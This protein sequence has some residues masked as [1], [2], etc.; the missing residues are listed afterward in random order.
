M[1]RRRSAEQPPQLPGHDERAEK[2]RARQEFARTKQIVL[3]LRMVFWVGSLAALVN[4]LIWHALPIDRD[5]LGGWYLLITGVYWAQ[6]LLMAGDALFVM[7]AP[8]PWSIVA[9]SLHTL[10]T[11]LV[12]FTA[13]PIAIAIYAFLLLCYWAAVGQAARVQRLMAANPE[14]QIVRRRIAS[15]R[16]VSGGVADAARS[17]RHRERSASA[18]GRMQMIG[19][20]GGAILLLAGVIWWLAR[21]PAVDDRVALF[22]GAWARGD[23]NTIDHMFELGPGDGDARRLREGLQRRGWSE[24]RPALSPGAIDER[25]VTASAR[26]AVDGGELE[27]SFRR[28]PITELWVLQ[29]VGLPPIRTGPVA[30]GVTAL[31]TAWGTGT[32]AVIG[33]LTDGMSARFGNGLKA[34]FERRGWGER[35]PELGEGRVQ[36]RGD[37]EVRIT[38]DVDGDE[39][40]FDLEWWQPRWRIASVRLP[41]DA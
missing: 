30:D 19:I 31:R 14:L 26:F 32:D 6:V 22:A 18:K 36:E 9:A 1:P 37:G 33:M 20:V 29:R 4:A 3:Y 12:V 24:G 35:R 23:Q 13:G 41:R 38:F 28:D 8:F 25:E 10:S 40:R 27:L 5:E 34:A 16:V 21:P 2:A 39:L 11:I 17:R 7:R 15:E